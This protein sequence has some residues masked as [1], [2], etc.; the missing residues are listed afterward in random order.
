MTIVERKTI[1]AATDEL[2]SLMCDGYE[3]IERWRYG[4]TRYER[5]QHRRNGNIALVSHNPTTGIITI[6]VNNKLKK[7]LCIDA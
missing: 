6:S 1:T 2:F 7:R 5:F 3:S 4:E